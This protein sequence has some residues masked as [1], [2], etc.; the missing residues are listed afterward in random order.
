MVNKVTIEGD[1]SIE[2]Y[3]L[4]DMKLIDTLPNNN[5]I[6]PNDKKP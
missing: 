2:S 1:N 6:T 4:F 3:N 5:C